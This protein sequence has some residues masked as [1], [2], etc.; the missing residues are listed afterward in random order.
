[1]ALLKNRE[2][3]RFLSTLFTGYNAATSVI[4]SATFHYFVKWERI[5]SPS[6]SADREYM[7][8]PQAVQFLNERGYPTSKSTF[9]KLEM[10]GEGP[11]PDGLWGNRH[12]YTPQRLLKWARSRCRELSK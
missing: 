8:R 5:V 4:P 10:L 9:D 7:T 11:S 3:R 1:L 12:L 6:T 2:T